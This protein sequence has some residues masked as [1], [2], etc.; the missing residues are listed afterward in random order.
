MKQFLLLLLCCLS[1]SIAI[2]QT[3]WT[4]L[5]GN[6][7]WNN[8]DNWDNNTVPTASDDVIIPTGSNVFLN[9]PGT[10]KSIDLQG[11]AVFEMNSNFT[12]DE[13]STFGPNSI[14]NWNT[15]FINGANGGASSL[16]N[17]GVLNLLSNGTKVITGG[18]TFQNEGTINIGSAGDLW[19]TQNST[20]TITSSGVLDMQT[21]AGNISWSGVSGILINE[22]LLKRSTS[23]GEA[24]IIIPFTNNNGTIQVESG[25]LSFQNTATKTFLNGTYNVFA[26]AIFDLDTEITIE[27]TLSG[28]I[29]GT[30][31]WNN[32]LIVADGTTASF[33]FSE[34]NSLNWTTGGLSGG[35]TLINNNTLSL[36]TGGTKVISGDTTFENY[37]TVNIASAGDVWI[38]GAGSIFN[39]TESGTLDMQADAGNITWSGV[40]GILINEGLLKR[41][42]SGGEAQ[43]IIPFTNNDGT[44]QVES[45]ILSF[46]NTATKTFL[47]GTYNVFADAIFDLDTE[48][49]IEGTLSGA[50]SG[51]LNWNNSL[52]VADGTTASFD[53]SEDNSL[54]WTT[55][56]LSGGGTLI[57]NNT[58][59]LTTGGTKVI[60]GDTT[61]ENYDTVNIASAGDVWIVG[62]ES[63]FNNTESGT[64]DMQADA[65]N[66]TWSGVEGLLYNE[67]LVKKTTSSGEAQIIIPFT[68]NDGTM[69][70]ES[71]TLSFQNTATKT[72]LN[73]TYN[74]FADAI[75]D[76]DTEITIEGT[77][78]GDIIGTLNWN[79]SLNVADTT[80]AIFDF[81]VDNNFN[82]T[83][84]NL[85]GGGTVINNTTI[86][87]TTGGTK[88]ITGDSTFENNGTVN[89]ESV[90]DLWITGTNTVFNN[91]SSG[92][93]ELKFDAG[94]ISWSGTSGTLNNFGTLR[95]ST[96]TGIAQIFVDLNNSGLI[97]VASGEL[98][99]VT[100]RPFA[101]LEDGIV[102]G[103]G[104]FD[105]PI[106]ANY[107]NNG[108]F[109]P[110]L[111]PGTLL[112][113]GDY[114]STA[115][116]VLDIELNGLIPDTEHDVL[117]ITG[118][119]NV[120]EG[121]VNVSMGFE[122]TIGDTFTIATTTGTIAIANL[123]SPIENVDFDG[124][125]YTFDVSYPD[126]NK[127]MLTITDKLDIL[128]P[129]IL[130]QNIT[131][132]LDASG[133]VSIADDA[134]DNGTT[135]NCTP[136]NELQF[137]LDITDFTC[138]DLG[139]NTVTLTVT[140]ND[141]NS[142]NAQATVTV[143]DVTNPTAIVQDIVVQLDASGN[144][145]I[146]ASEIDNGSSDNCSVVS[147][148]LDISAFTCSDLGDNTVELTVTDQSGN[149]DSELA[150]VTVIDTETPTVVTQDLVVE[151]DASGNANILASE[152]DNGSSDNCS[153]VSL[154]L[155]ISAFTCA[156]LGDNT[157][158][159]TVTDQSGNQ[160][161]GL[162]TVTVL[163]TIDPVIMC[164]E[165]ISV[166]VEGNYTLPDYIL[167][168]VVTAFDNC[169][170]TVTQSPVPGTVLPDGD[171]P[172]V[173]EITD[174][175][176]NNAVC[177]FT[178]KVDDTTLSVDDKELTDANIIVFPNPIVDQLT[179][180]NTSRLDLVDMEIIDITGK[181]INR[182]DLDRMD[183]SITVS[184]TAYASGMYFVKINALN[185]SITKK[186]IK[187]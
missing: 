65:G 112:V 135:D 109:A 3:T 80:T 89:F 145:S 31:N 130:T 187:E 97:E 33:D 92:L 156:D 129:D 110:G 24:Q 34:D 151:L 37:D 127:V 168:G 118:N 140:D 47:N 16:T 180:K 148:D 38:V 9:V 126:N 85:L 181:T 107:T 88:V 122:A 124:K 154:D 183:Q 108:I 82:W 2:A 20:L 74:V 70:V 99:I 50:I 186:V 125:R 18:M 21:D 54:N 113:Q 119:N 93:L 73:G 137:S 171:Y 106:T 90:G 22:G 8:V 117:A 170:F 13:N 77:L 143:E 40:S 111:S 144:A 57:N 83:N 86:S 176:G 142:A 60:S 46:Q 45:G 43:I 116:S 84:G 1:G 160:D 26:D 103:V 179:V 79:S 152:I 63:I 68:N 51:T 115:T 28:A 66:I 177:N 62:A 157:V 149:Q 175:A 72:F 44:I 132:Q 49:T 165:N 167:D 158:E 75:F 67:G 36:T 5:G 182:I 96:S 81:S 101:N 147:L 184:L 102:K 10:V 131:V 146:L 48:I 23:G 64:L 159:L 32:S 4:G 164:S 173:F 114:T 11:N 174:D 52:I 19:I 128:P 178:L 27:G 6:T 87:L 161:S 30:L 71:G 172:I 163:D 141:N 25:I 133:N 138:A 69:Q 166:E 17:Q 94:N 150:T 185:S 155:D 53:F 98:E 134:V 35:G 15:G 55:G 139:D 29:S 78:S 169:G 105:L 136:T 41:S 76:L 162:A 39:N 59:S 58:L 42:T 12:F 7:N 123:Q 121:S 120:F 56:G 153:V 100:S 104:I 61:F 91:T 14:V 95:R